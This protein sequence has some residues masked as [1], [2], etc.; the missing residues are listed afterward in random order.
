ML[1]QSRDIIDKAQ[2]MDER[3]STLLYI[4]H[5][6]RLSSSL[7]ERW[8]LDGLG[9]K[10]YFSKKTLL[11]RPKDAYA[12]FEEFNAVKTNY[13]KFTLMIV[14][15]PTVPRITHVIATCLER[16]SLTELGQTENG[17]VYADDTSW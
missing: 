11:S 3:W 1:V 15:K 2:I 17:I 12:D 13:S 6:N 4:W 10:L 8:S 5:V 9:E 14:S 7:P 16:D